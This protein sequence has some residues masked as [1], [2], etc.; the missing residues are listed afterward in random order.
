MYLMNLAVLSVPRTVGLKMI[1]ALTGKQ[2]LLN[3]KN[4]IISFQQKI[5]SDTTMGQLTIIL[6]EITEEQLNLTNKYQELMLQFSALAEMAQNPII[7]V[8]CEEINRLIQ[9]VIDTHGKIET[10]IPLIQLNRDL[11]AQISKKH[12]LKHIPTKLKEIEELSIRITHNRAL[13][14]ANYRQSMG[15]IVF[16]DMKDQKSFI[17]AKKVIGDY[18]SHSAWGYNISLLGIHT[19]SNNITTPEVEEFIQQA[20]IRYH[21]ITLDET[22][23]MKKEIKVLFNN[24]CESMGRSGRNSFPQQ[25][26]S[27]EDI[28]VRKVQLREGI[29]DISKIVTKMLKD[30]PEPEIKP[31][32]SPY[33]VLT[34]HVQYITSNFEEPYKEGTGN[35]LGFM[36]GCLRRMVDLQ[37]II[38]ITTEIEQ[39]I[40]E[41][42]TI[43]KARIQ[44]NLELV[45]REEMD[46]AFQKRLGLGSWS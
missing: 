38:P 37:K 46:R 15:A 13:Y 4:K 43:F 39:V 29:D 9:G 26:M 22:E 42:L 24:F 7:R 17:Y 41:A 35:S 45:T 23:T 3:N 16:F 11:I 27:S 20:D 12:Q 36:Q 40:N 21:K 19:S 6:P 30:L 25:R 10:V 8:E 2:K 5:V 28:K 1:V 34:R 32:L 33:Y 44:P 18:K 14:L 31:N